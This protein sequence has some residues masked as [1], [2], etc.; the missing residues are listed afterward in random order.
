MSDLAT[1]DQEHETY[2]LKHM[3]G[4]KEYYSHLGFA[5]VEWEIRTVEKWT[6]ASYP[7]LELGTAEHFALYQQAIKDGA[8]YN[9]AT[10]KR[11]EAALTPEFIGLEGNRVEVVDRWDNRYRFIIGK[12]TGWMPI[13]IERKRCNS[14]GGGAFVGYPCKE[15][16]VIGK[17]GKKYLARPYE[18]TTIE[19]Y[20]Y[21]DPTETPYIYIP[22]IK[23]EG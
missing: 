12:S 15:V 22:R 23:R 5:Y 8:A 3:Y 19:A 2:G 17:N 10:G 16:W 11:C 4:K 20:F 18:G 21:T 6:G 7:Q 1:I 9:R 14:D 13:H